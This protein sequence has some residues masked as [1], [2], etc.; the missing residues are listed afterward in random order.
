M[1]NNEGRQ[2]LNGGLHTLPL[3][4]QIREPRQRN[5]KIKNLLT[6]L[7]SGVKAIGMSEYGFNS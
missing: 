7:K 5:E 1:F 4:K 2:M 6:F 3:N